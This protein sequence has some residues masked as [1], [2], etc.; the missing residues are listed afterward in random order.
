M[1]NFFL[2]VFIFPSKY[3]RNAEDHL[4]SERKSN[5]DRISESVYSI[6]TKPICTE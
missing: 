3:D 1:S 6:S 2:S 5:S 4:K